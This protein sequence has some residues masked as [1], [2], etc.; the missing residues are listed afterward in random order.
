MYPGHPTTA[1]MAARFVSLIPT[2]AKA[3]SLSPVDVW[4]TADVS[5]LHIMN[6]IKLKQHLSYLIQTTISV[7]LYFM[8]ILYICI[9]RA[10]LSRKTVLKQL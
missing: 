9:I 10:K 2:A 1:E 6:L 3:Q 5:S 8:Y 4:L 7:Y